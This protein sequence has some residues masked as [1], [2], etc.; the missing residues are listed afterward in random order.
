M[1]LCCAVQVLH[2][3]EGLGHYLIYLRIDEAPVLAKVRDFVDGL[4]IISFR[5]L[6]VLIA[7]FNRL[8]ET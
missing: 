2:R 5:L 4:S 3:P 7:W 1:V 8:T 6:S